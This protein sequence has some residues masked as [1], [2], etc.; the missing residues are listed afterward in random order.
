MKIKMKIEEENL[1]FVLLDGE[2]EAGE[3]SWSE[4]GDELMIIDH[5][6]VDDAYRGKGY[7]EDLIYCGV[8]KARE[9]NKKILP[10]CPFASKEF[11][12]KSQYSDVL[13]KMD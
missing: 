10:L 7:A 5:T 12:N 13:A 1:R 9:E 4:A 3:M 11:Q 8:K 2:K 6:F